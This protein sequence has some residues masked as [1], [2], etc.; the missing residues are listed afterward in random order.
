MFGIYHDFW[1][2]GM[3][4]VVPLGFELED[5]SGKPYLPKPNVIKGAKKRIGLRWQGNSQFEHEHH[6][7]F[8]FD[9]MFDAVKDANVEFISLQRDEGSEAQPYW[10]NEVPL[11]SWEDTRAAAASCDLVISSCTSVSHLAGAMGVET[12]VITPIMPYFLYA[13]EGDKTPY[14]DCF[15]MFRQESFDNWVAPFEKIKAKLSIG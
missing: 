5:I 3:S 10:V 13:L 1:V 8:P 9:L 12:W 14:Y 4:S 11:N 6:K 2:A 7:K 15:T